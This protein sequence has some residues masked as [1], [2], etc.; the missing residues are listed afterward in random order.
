[1]EAI[2]QLASGV[3]H[4]FNNKLMVI[5]GNSELAKMDIDDSEKV[6]QYLSQINQAAEQS[7][8]ITSRLLAF[9][10]QQVISPQK[11]NANLIIA[12]S[13]KSLSRLIG[14]QISI[15]LNSCNLYFALNVESKMTFSD[16]LQNGPKLSGTD[17]IWS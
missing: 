9:S 7:R 5:I 2:G 10:R 15:T 13:L 6:R 11:L 17:A 8:I 16:R 3:A 14:E 1:M 4:D 12:D